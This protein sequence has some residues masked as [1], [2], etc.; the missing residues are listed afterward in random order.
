MAIFPYENLSNRLFLQYL[1]IKFILEGGGKEQLE[2]E[3]KHPLLVIRSLGAEMEMDVNSRCD[4]ILVAVLFAQAC[5][6]WQ[7]SLV[8]ALP[9]IE[10]PVGALSRCDSCFCTRVVLFKMAAARLEILYIETSVQY[11]ILFFRSPRIGNIPSGFLIFIF[12][13]SKSSICMLVATV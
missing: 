2:M 9:E 6:K 13:T 8:P 1:P 5:S 4:R 7:L 10:K 11:C 12:P 3:Q